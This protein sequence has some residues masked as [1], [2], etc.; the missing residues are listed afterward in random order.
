MCDIEDIL[1]IGLTERSREYYEEFAK[2]N[3]EWLEY[4]GELIEWTLETILAIIDFIATAFLSLAI[5][6]LMAMLYAIQP[7]LYILLRS[8]RQ[9]YVLAGLLY[10]EP[11]ELESAHARNLTT[12]YQCESIVRGSSNL[13]QSQRYI[14]GAQRQHPTRS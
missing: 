9:V 12:N 3:E 14:I 1:A 8:F 13:E 10:P 7:S 11:D 4:L 6:T 2:S 5:I